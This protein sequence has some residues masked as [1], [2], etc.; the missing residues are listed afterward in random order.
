MA[1]LSILPQWAKGL[2]AKRGPEH[3]YSPQAIGWLV[4]A[5]WSI[6]SPDEILDK[7]GKTRAELRKVLADDEIGAAVDTRRSA[8]MATPWRLEPG[9]GEV[10]KFCWSQIEKH[11]DVLITQSLNAVLFGH[12]VTERIWAQEGSRNVLAVVEERPFEWFTPRRDGRLILSNGIATNSDEMAVNTVDKYLLIRNRPSWTYPSGEALL[13]RCYWPWFLRSAG[14]RMWARFLERNAAPI[15]AGKGQD[16]KKLAEALQRAVQ[17]AVVAVGK[18]D[19]VTSINAGSRGDAYNAFNDAC[20]ARI[21]KTILGQ[22][23][24]TQVK[25]NGSYAAAKVHDLVRMDRRLSDMRLATRAIQSVIDSL[26]RWNYPGAKVPQ[27]VM[28][29]PKGL[30]RD[31]AERDAILSRIGV[32]FTDQYFI[33]RYDFEQGEIRIALN[34]AQPGQKLAM[35]AVDRG[36]MLDQLVNAA[37]ARTGD[38]IEASKIREAIQASSGPEDLI[39]RLGELTTNIDDD[40]AGLVERALFAADVM[41]YVHDDQHGQR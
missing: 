10:T 39:E 25:G 16:T 36:A 5:I 23:L 28:G 12:S 22:T 41:G 32:E 13:S 20:E 38:P 33:N 31:R 17:S 35:P 19:E 14:W 6:D 34:P 24:T 7:A 4:D 27:F 40:F 8:L 9:D 18:D 15:L 3:L 30:E 37:I 1:T 21:Q 29:D 26:V 11:A 2:F